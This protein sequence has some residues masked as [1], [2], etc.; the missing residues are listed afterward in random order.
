MHLANQRLGKP[1]KLSQG[2]YTQTS[3][4]KI[5]WENTLDKGGCRAPVEEDVVEREK[6]LTQRGTQ[7][8]RAGTRY[9]NI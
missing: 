9:N 3:Y 5:Q 6:L 8:H 7:G 2:A 4:P 1:D